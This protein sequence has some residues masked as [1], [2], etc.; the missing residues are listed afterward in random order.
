M[1][2]LSEDGRASWE[3]VER[4]IP[5]RLRLA[6]A[7]IDPV[8]YSEAVGMGIGTVLYADVSD[9]AWNELLAEYRE[10]IARRDR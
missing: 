8:D 1:D 7:R 4:G 5:L 10:A 3:S 9:G 2:D 6:D